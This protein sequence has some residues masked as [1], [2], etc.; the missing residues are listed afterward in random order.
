MVF[1]NRFAEALTSLLIVFRR[2]AFLI[3]SPYKTLR[4]ISLEEDALQVGIIFLLVFLYFQFAHKL[5]AFF[6]PPYIIFIFFVINFFFTVLFFY[7]LSQPAKKNISLKSLVFTLSYSLFPTLLWFIVSSLFYYFLPPP[8]SASLLGKA[9]SIFFIAFSVSVLAWKIILFYL[10]VRFSTRLQF[11]AVIYLILLY[12]CI[13]I[14]YALLL[15]YFK[16][17]RVP[18]I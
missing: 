5:R 18:F 11:Y 12:L 14:P 3:V 16:I 13:L 8:R 9:F 17:F 1:R 15:Y 2:F 4:R 6:Y 10:S 7:F